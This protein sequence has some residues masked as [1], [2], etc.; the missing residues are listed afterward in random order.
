[1]KRW[2]DSKGNGERKRKTWENDGMEEN[3]YII[4]EGGDKCMKS[5]KGKGYIVLD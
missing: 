3:G 2:L 1:M 5:D 4:R